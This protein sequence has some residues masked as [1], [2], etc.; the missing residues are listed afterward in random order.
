MIWK[1]ERLSLT[2]D[3]VKNLLRYFSEKILSL[4]YQ[5][6]LVPREI[7]GDK[8]KVKT[9]GIFLGDGCSLLKKGLTFPFSDL[10]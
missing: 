2:S 5:D 1:E 3:D 6:R 7:Q 8:L 10:S 4:L 9:L